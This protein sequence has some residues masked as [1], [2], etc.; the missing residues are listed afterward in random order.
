MGGREGGE[1]GGWGAGEGGEV[2]VKASYLM[3]YSFS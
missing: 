3:G 2:G 1:V